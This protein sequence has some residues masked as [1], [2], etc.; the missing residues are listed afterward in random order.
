MYNALNFNSLFSNS[1]AVTVLNNL[2]LF[3]YMCQAT[4]CIRIFTT[5]NMQHHVFIVTNQH[6]RNSIQSFK[7]FFVGH[8]VVTLR[9]I[10]TVTVQSPKTVIHGRLLLMS[11]ILIV[12][13]FE[14][15]FI[16]RTSFLYY[17]VSK[18]MRKLQLQKIA[19]VERSNYHV[20]VCS[21]CTLQ[22]I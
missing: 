10:L 20:I 2:F 5:V 11:F 9:F 22:T 6:K 17:C 18:N 8:C 19:S 13:V 16:F 21:Y 3:T 15:V 14:T 7:C 1:V 4:N 12:C